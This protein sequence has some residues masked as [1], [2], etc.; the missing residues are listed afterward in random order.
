AD[1]LTIGKPEIIQNFKPETLKKFYKD[2]Y[3][4]DLMAVIAVGDF[5]KSAVEGLIKAH[6]GA[7]PATPSPRPRPTHDVPSHEGSVYAITTD[8]E[9][10]T[11][12]V[13][14]ENIMPA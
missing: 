4:P 13:T 14:I 7:I 12:S 2:W 11:T 3:R 9:L 1:R 10:T 6:F 5:D 8:K